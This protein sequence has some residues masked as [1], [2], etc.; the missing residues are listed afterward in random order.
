MTAPSEPRDCNRGCGTRVI[1]ARRAFS[2]GGRWLALEA[3][4][5]PPF[6]QASAGCYV[7]VDGTAYTVNEAIE[8]F[9]VRLEITDTK[10]RDLVSSYPWHRAHYDDDQVGGDQ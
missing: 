4:D 3:Q 8:D 5:Q 10:A 6:E 2:S 7:V 9:Q 1:L